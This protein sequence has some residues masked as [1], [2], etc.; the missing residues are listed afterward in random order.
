MFKKGDYINSLNTFGT[1]FSIS[2]SDPNK[3]VMILEKG[4]HDGQS[5]SH[6]GNYT[7]EYIPGNNYYFV[8]LSNCKLVKPKESEKLTENIFYEIY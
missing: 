1:I 5:E 2:K 3:A 7:K 6:W 8:L 4:G